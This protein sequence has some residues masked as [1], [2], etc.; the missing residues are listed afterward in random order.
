M[1][2]FLDRI[3]GVHARVASL[4]QLSSTAPPDQVQEKNMRRTGAVVLVAILFVL[5]PVEPVGQG[6][7]DWIEDALAKARP[8]TGAPGFSIA[9][10]KDG[11]LAWAGGDGI[12][13]L[14]HDVP[15]GANTIY[16]IGSITKT[17]T[18][19]AVLQLVE[20]GLVGLDDPIAKYIPAYPKERSSV[21]TVRHVLTH[22]SGIRHYHY[23]R[24]E[25]EGLPPTYFATSVDALNIYGVA[26]EPLLF[27]PGTN[28]NY[29]TYA[30]RLLGDVIEKASGITWEAYLRDQVFRPAGMT[31]SLVEHPLEIVPRR[32]GHYRKDGMGNPREGIKQPWPS[33]ALFINAPY[34]DFSY[35]W[36]AA[37]VLSTAEDLAR[38][39]IALGNGTLLK[40]ATVELMQT[41]HVL[42]GGEVTPFGLGWRVN[43]DEMGRTWVSHGGGTTG[44]TSHILRFPK[45]RTSVSVLSNVEGGQGIA[46]FARRIAIALI[47]GKA[48]SSEPEVD[49]ADSVP[50]RP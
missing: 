42:P 28:T 32:A 16:R 5:S 31:S 17:I 45:G 11:Q 26:E 20:K 18:A 50:A 39:D 2:R 1:M 30:F 34:V 3:T 46:A 8:A 48:L 19:V 29:S 25:K 40:P 9:V 6:M 7:R 38:Y 10:V 27:E 44:Q 23:E 24:G 36:S 4:T 15:A 12:A 41:P 37:A 33:G 43:T 35:K 47:E 14:E 22:T 13:H 49:L 21:I